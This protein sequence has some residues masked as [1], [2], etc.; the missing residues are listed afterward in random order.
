MRKIQET[1]QTQSTTDQDIMYIAFELSNSTWR[2]AFSDGN[3]K[4]HVTIKARDL[5]QLEREIIKAEKTIQD[6]VDLINSTEWTLDSTEIVRNEKTGQPMSLLVKGTALQL[7]TLQKDL[8]KAIKSLEQL[9]VKYNKEKIE[10]RTKGKKFVHA[11][12]NND[13]WS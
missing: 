6:R 10:R 3:K 12:Q 1:L 2:L 11:G 5:K 9:K 4:R 13:F 8:E 7:N